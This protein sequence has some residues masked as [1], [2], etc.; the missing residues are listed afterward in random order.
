MK[1]VGTGALAVG[2]KRAADA[3]DFKGKI[4][5]ILGI[6]GNDQRSGAFTTGQLQADS[7]KTTEVGEAW[8]TSPRFEDVFGK[9]EPKEKGV[10]R[11]TVDE[12]KYEVLYPHSSFK[13]MMAVTNTFQSQI[14]EAASEFNLPSDLVSGM[15][16]IENGGGID[17]SSSRGARGPAQLKKDTAERYGMIVNDQVDERID[18]NKCFKVMCNYLSD[19]RELFGGNLSLAIWGYHAG[20]GN[21]TSALQH[22]FQKKEGVDYGRFDEETLANPELYKVVEQNYKKKGPES[23]F[24][25]HTLF[26]DEELM[27]FIRAEEPEGLGLTDETELYVYKAVGGAEIFAEQNTD[28]GSAQ[29]TQ[30]Q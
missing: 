25:V 12:M 15:V 10:A 14:T 29:I 28:S 2:A 7:Q 5:R 26:A 4:D 23:G 20:E 30:Q 18:P 17:L 22:Y 9:L 24:N 11:S 8:V 16:F 6:S 13:D 27:E 1:V 3:I 21:V 19:L